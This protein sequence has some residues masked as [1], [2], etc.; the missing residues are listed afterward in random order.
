ML[1][2]NLASPWFI[3]SRS[4]RRA[5]SFFHCFRV[6]IQLLSTVPERTVVIKEQFMLFPRPLASAKDC[7][8]Q[9]SNTAFL[10]VSKS[11]WAVGKKRK[12]GF[13]LLNQYFFVTL[14][15]NKN[16]LTQSHLVKP[17][18]IVVLVDD[19][20]HRRHRVDAV[21]P[22]WS[23]R[24]NWGWK[25]CLANGHRKPDQPRCGH[26]VATGIIRPVTVT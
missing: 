7:T 23:N 22:L 15:W 11:L 12:T 5:I 3:L 2:W 26:V 16:L 17:H 18:K 4:R 6:P 21:P 10:K 25:W 20:G 14:G 1:L 24:R 8:P 19:L 9:K 13:L